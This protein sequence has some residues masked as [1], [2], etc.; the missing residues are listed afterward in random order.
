VAAVLRKDPTLDVE[1]ESGNYGEFT[2][3]VEGK[4]VLSAGMIAVLGILPS[5]RKVQ[6]VIDQE[7][8]KQRST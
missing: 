2:V 5:I 8:P 4:E 3:L 6:E 1:L 7:R